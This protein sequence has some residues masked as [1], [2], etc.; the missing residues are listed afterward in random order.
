[1]EE[2]K[3]GNGGKEVIGGIGFVLFL[4][5]AAG[6][7]SPNVI[8]PALMAF[9]GLAIIALSAFRERRRAY[10]ISYRVCKWK[11]PKLRKRPER[12]VRV[13][14]YI[15]RGSGYGYSENLQEW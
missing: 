5:G 8:V 15:E 2:K 3:K 1:M 7:D 6:M 9:T 4:L 12:F 14:F 13:A 11:L 10:G